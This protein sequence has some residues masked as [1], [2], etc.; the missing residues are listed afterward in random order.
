[1]LSSTASTWLRASESA[2]AAAKLLHTKELWDSSMSR[3]YYA[4]YSASHAVAL[5]QGLVVYGRHAP[6]N[7]S[8]KD[9]LHELWGATARMKLEIFKR[10]LLRDALQECQRSRM[11]ADYQPTR[12]D[13]FTCKQNLAYAEQIVWFARSVLSE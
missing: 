10:N 7:W 3:A 6:N 9:I 8:H 1:M 13:L 11:M 2:L 12:S 5:S 4:A